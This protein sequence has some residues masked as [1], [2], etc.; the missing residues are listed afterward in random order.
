MVKTHLNV[1]AG[2]AVFRRWLERIGNDAPRKMAVKYRTR[3]IDLL[4]INQNYRFM[5]MGLFPHTHK[6]DTKENALQNEKYCSAFS[7]YMAEIASA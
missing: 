7:L 4:A 6:C 5:S 1:E 3:L 2:P